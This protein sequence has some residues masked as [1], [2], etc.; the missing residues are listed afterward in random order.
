MDFKTFLFI[1]QPN[2]FP[3]IKQ[4]KFYFEFSD[5]H[6]LRCVSRLTQNAAAQ[7]A[8]RLSERTFRSRECSADVKPPIPVLKPV[9][10]FTN[11]LCVER[12][13]TDVLNAYADTF[14]MELF[15]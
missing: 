9:S 8:K 12:R 11:V 10:L 3:F 2:L 14:G 5:L 15:S 13:I 7:N 1:K 6:D 4:L